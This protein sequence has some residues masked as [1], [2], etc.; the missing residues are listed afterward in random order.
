MMA[1]MQAQVDG[2]QMQINDL[3]GQ[4]AAMQQALPPESQEQLAQAPNMGMPAPNPLEATP[5]GA[6]A[7]MESGEASPSLPALPEEEL[8]GQQVDSFDEMLT[9]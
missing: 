8:P 2:Q 6:P 4:M 5:E 3:Q 1:D 7:P 9:I